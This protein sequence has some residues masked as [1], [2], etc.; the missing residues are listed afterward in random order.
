MKKATTKTFSN[1]YIT[2]TAIKMR[3]A[4]LLPVFF[5]RQNALSSWFRNVNVMSKSR[6]IFM[7]R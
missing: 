6:E 7:S 1:R 3:I 2:T 5:E 4:M